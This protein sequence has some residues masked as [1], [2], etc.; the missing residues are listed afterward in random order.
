M[1]RCEGA[2]AGECMKQDP[3]IY[4]GSWSI[5]YC[6]QN[7]GS[8]CYHTAIADADIAVQVTEL[9]GWPDH[10]RNRIFSGDR[11]RYGGFGSYRWVKVAGPSSHSAVYDAT[12][13]AINEYHDRVYFLSSN[14]FVSLVLSGAGI[15]L[16][17]E[18]AEAL[19]GFRAAGIC[20]HARCK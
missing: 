20:W 16:T 5:P 14:R 3:G 17:R 7:L 8:E 19:G 4:V 13:G 1:K 9:M 2:N 15:T 10:R 18:Q 12:Y 6:K 11:P